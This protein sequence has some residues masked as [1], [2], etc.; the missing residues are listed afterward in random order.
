[1]K[2]KSLIKPKKVVKKPIKPSS[3][4]PKPQ[5]VVTPPV[6][7][8]TPTLPPAPDDWNKTKVMTKKERSK[9]LS[10]I[11]LNSDKY[12]DK[13]KAIETLGKLNGD[14]EKKVKTA[15]SITVTLSQNDLLL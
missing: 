10:Y 3:P 12:A 15:S 11:I 13:I 5:V 7:I 14:Y 2:K 9:Y 4:L 6:V 1:M 8:A